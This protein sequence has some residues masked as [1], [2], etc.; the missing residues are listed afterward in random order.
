MSLPTLQ[1]ALRQRFFNT[2]ARNA[3]GPLQFAP[4]STA[5]YY[6]TTSTCIYCLLA[7]LDVCDFESSLCHPSLHLSTCQFSGDIYFILSRPKHFFSKVSVWDT[8]IV[9]HLGTKI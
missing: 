4:C 7:S 3:P 9:V 5:T 1:I 8:L 2:Y 6:L